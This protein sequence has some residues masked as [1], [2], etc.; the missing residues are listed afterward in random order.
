[1]VQSYALKDGHLFAP[2]SYRY[3]IPRGTHIFDEV[4]RGRKQL[5][6]IFLARSFSKAATSQLALVVTEVP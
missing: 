5:F 4:A 6:G 2:C 3:S 1:M